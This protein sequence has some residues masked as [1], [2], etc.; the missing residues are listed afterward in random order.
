MS[1]MQRYLTKNPHMV[2]VPSKAPYYLAL[3]TEADWASDD[4]DVIYN[5]YEHST[6]FAA[7][8]VAETQADYEA[9][10]ADLAK[11]IGAG[12][13]PIKARKELLAKYPCSTGY[14]AKRDRRPTR[15]RGF[16]IASQEEQDA[17]HAARRAA[18]EAEQA[19]FV[20]ANAAA[21]AKNK[22]DEEDARKSGVMS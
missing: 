7:K 22:A 18:Y 20:E 6:V 13:G 17:Y 19:P 1:N 3:H 16:L 21:E 11:L 14:I 9:W 8:I 12:R 15:K 4:V 2:Y 5:G 10:L